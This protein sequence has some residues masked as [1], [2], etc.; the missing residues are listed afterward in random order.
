MTSPH[1]NN[2]GSDLRRA[3]VPDQTNSTFTDIV[4][5]PPKVFNSA[6]AGAV[7]KLVTMSTNVIHARMGITS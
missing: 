5:P 6:H 1:L 3:E 7:E 2:T 4:S